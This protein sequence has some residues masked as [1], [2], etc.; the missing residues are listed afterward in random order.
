MDGRP[1]HHMFYTCKPSY[2]Q[3]LHVSVDCIFDLTHCVLVASQIL[4]NI[5]SGIWLVMKP[6]PEPMLTC[7]QL[8]IIEQTSMKMDSQC[9]YNHFHSITYIWNVLCKT[10]A[11]LFSAQCV[12]SFPLGNWDIIKCIISNT[13]QWLISLA[14]PLELPSVAPFTNMV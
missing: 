8:D 1:F 10:A 5:G 2:Y 6:S 14:F 13:F 3:L 9:M 11:I 4:V 7:C 12:P